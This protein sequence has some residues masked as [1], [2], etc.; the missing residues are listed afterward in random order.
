MAKINH[1]EIVE[2]PDKRQ[3]WLPSFECLYTAPFFFFFCYKTKFF[4]YKNI[5]RQTSVKSNHFSRVQSIRFYY[6]FVWRTKIK[7]QL[8][9]RPVFAPRWCIV[10]SS[11]NFT[12]LNGVEEATNPNRCHFNW[13]R[14][15]IL[16][17]FFFILSHKTRLGGELKQGREEKEVL[18]V[19]KWFTLVYTFLSLHYTDG[20]R[21]RGE[22]HDLSTWPPSHGRNWKKKNFLKKLNSLFLSFFFPVNDEDWFFFRLYFNRG[23]KFGKE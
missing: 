12:R 4:V 14:T 8:T 16:F 2:I 19:S 5:H 6:S 11:I 7:N 17:F 9:S 22:R 13:L 18:R 20:R 10:M 3:R 21:K 1:I 23:R 15:G